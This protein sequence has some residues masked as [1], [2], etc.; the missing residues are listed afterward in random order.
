MAARSFSAALARYALPVALVATSALV[1]LLTRQNRGLATRY[2]KLQRM[3]TEP[4]RGFVVPTFRASTLSGRPATIGEHPSGGR[5]VLFIFRTTCPYCEA[6]VPAWSM[7]A[8]V[9]DTMTS[10]PVDVFGIALDSSGVAEAYSLSKGLRYDV[11]TFPNR[12]LSRLYRTGSV[13]V[14]LVL[15]SV[16]TV[17]YSRV[18]VLTDP[19]V[20]DSVL[21]AVHWQGRAAETAKRN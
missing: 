20:I 11:L 16:G 10:P 1:L 5:Q 9:L 21:L 7:L 2:Q 12:K 19:T 8:T 14:T 13:P 17:V 4:Y 15:D 6:S 18:G 3:V